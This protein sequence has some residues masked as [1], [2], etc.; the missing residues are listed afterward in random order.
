MKLAGS[1]SWSV[2]GFVAVADADQVAA[3]TAVEEEP[4]KA[5][6]MIADA[7][8]YFAV[9]AVAV[10]LAVDGDVGDDADE[11]AVGAVAAEAVC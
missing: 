8:L 2:F 11:A 10:V 7:G 3:G 5:A 9:D 1:G 6:G 4:G